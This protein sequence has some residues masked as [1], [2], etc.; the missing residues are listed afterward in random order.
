MQ[1]YEI[2]SCKSKRFTHIFSDAK[3]FQS[4]FTVGELLVWNKEV[5]TKQKLE[6]W[7]K[8]RI[9]QLRK[10]ADFI[11]EDFFFSLFFDLLYILS[12][13]LASFQITMTPPTTAI[14][15]ADRFTIHCWWKWTTSFGSDVFSYRFFF[16]IIFTTG[17]LELRLA[18]DT[19]FFFLFGLLS[20]LFQKKKL[21]P[22]FSIQENTQQKNENL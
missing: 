3:S 8:E 4:C 20:L 13:T 22:N 15:F 14:I 21:N 16:L 19:T 7:K 11:N 17:I 12:F 6:D 10:V 5:K 2:K 18:F 1:Y 9:E